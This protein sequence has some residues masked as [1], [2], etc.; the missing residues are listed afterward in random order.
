MA[1]RLKFFLNDDNLNN[2]QKVAQK[3]DNWTA[4]EKRKWEGGRVFFIGR[5]KGMGRSFFFS[6]TMFNGNGKY[7]WDNKKNTMRLLCV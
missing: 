2:A 7:Y 1:S 6:K 5:K 3:I 4:W